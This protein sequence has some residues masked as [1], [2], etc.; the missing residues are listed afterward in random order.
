M[1]PATLARCKEPFTSDEVSRSWGC[2]L[3]IIRHRL[4]REGAG[5]LTIVASILPIYYI[6]RHMP[7]KKSLVGTEGLLNVRLCPKQLCCLKLGPF[8]SFPS[9]WY[10][11]SLSPLSWDFEVICWKKMASICHNYKAVAVIQTETLQPTYADVSPQTDLPRI[12]N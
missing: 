5:L 8:S 12:D 9:C 11:L 1:L 2:S 4:P 10:L 6:Y 7:R 3:C